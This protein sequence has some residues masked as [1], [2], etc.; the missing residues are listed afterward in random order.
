MNSW[1]GTVLGPQAEHW[2]VAPPAEKVLPAQGMQVPF[3]R[4]WP[5][6]QPADSK[7]RGGS[8]ELA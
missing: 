3:D 8:A 4:P 7:G 5:A 6:V 1:S 2:A